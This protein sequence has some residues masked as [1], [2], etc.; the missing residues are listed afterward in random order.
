MPCIAHATKIGTVFDPSVIANFL[1][2]FDNSLTPPFAIIASHTVSRR[3]S[4]RSVALA[5]SCSSDMKE[6][7]GKQ[8]LTKPKAWLN[9]GR[10]AMREIILWVK[11]QLIFVMGMQWI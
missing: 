6:P 10:P 1:D 3:V 5:A 4:D 2:I 8:N 7:E 9:L 11:I